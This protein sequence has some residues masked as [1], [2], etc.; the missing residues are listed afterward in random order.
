MASTPIVPLFKSES[1]SSSL[2]PT[3]QVSADDV[4]L[5]LDEEYFRIKE[6]HLVQDCY[7]KFLPLIQKEE[8]LD[9]IR[10]NKY[11]HRICTCCTTYM[12]GTCKVLILYRKDDVLMP[13]CH[14]C[15]MFLCLN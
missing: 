12:C 9:L 3:R 7:N 6:L 1:S 11:I 8:A 4:P 13:Y 2:W 10:L 5:V 15:E 14:R